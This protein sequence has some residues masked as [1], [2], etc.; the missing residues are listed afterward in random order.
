[1]VILGGAQW[2]SNFKVFGPPFDRNSMYTFHKYWTEPTQ[3][4]IQEYLD[5]RDRYGVPIWM[6]ESGENSDEWIGKFTHTLEE[7]QVGWCYWP[8]KKM[9]Q[10]SSVVT[11]ARPSHWD[12]IVAYAKLP[13]GAGEAEKRAA[14][15]PS[16]ADAQE[17][18]NDLL[19]QIRFEN[20][21]VNQG[22][23]QALGLGK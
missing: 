20:R 4:V 14:S 6:G 19:K 9:D 5:Y 2:D 16:T 23:L 21:R 10:T 17:A 11:F 12:E 8:Y 13:G 18:L 22:Y 7:N 1:M 15:R 3:K